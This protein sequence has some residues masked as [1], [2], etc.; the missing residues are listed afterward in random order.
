MQ[1]QISGVRVTYNGA[2]PFSGRFDGIDYDFDKGTVLVMSH[3]AAQHIFGYG[4]DNDGKVKAFARHGWMSSSDQFTHAQSKL[5]EFQFDEVS[6][7]FVERLAMSEPSNDAGPLVNGGDGEEGLVPSGPLLG[8][9]DL[10]E[11]I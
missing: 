6:A 3:D 11:V 9:D 5:G 8:P 4:A 2:A 1:T 10:D 7:N